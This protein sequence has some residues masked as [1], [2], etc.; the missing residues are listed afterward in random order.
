MSEKDMNSIF[1]VDEEGK[2]I[3]LTIPELDGMP[4][5]ILTGKKKTELNSEEV[6]RLKIYVRELRERN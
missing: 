3:D 6:T 1:A 2:F 4:E 5:L